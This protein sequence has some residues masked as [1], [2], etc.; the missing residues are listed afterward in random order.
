M[1]NWPRWPSEDTPFATGQLD[2]NQGINL[3]ESKARRLMEHRLMHHWYIFNSSLPHLG[4]VAPWR[5]FWVTYLPDLGLAHENVQFGMLATAAT[6]LLRSGKDDDV[7]AARQSY[8]L[9]ALH[10]QREQVAGLCAEN[11]EPVCFGALLITV[12][13][14]AMLKERDLSDPQQQPYQ[15]PL[16]WLQ[17]G[18]GAGT[19]LWQSVEAI[20]KESR[21]RAHPA[22]MAIATTYPYFGRDQSYFAPA[23]RAHFPGVL[24]PHLPPGD[25][26][27][28]RVD[29]KEDETREAY[30]KA[31]SYV[32]SIQRGIDDGEPLYVL[33]RRIQTF[34]LLAP[35]RFIGLLALRRPR[36]LVVLAH[37][38]AAVSQV[39]GV[40]WLGE[41][42]S[43]AADSTA[44]REIRA[45]RDA[46]PK[47]WMGTMVWPLDQVGLGGDQDVL[48]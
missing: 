4:S 36:A 20:V 17:L 25:D 39:K 8:F 37:F 44:V 3:P 40:W 48:A 47:E 11:A 6:H 19:A 22:L 41:A 29:E 23:M 12:C 45:I 28:A 42:D 38:W 21:E 9:S 24:S 46:L 5:S 13:S 16:E 7:Y 35:P 18:R 33:A 15:P 27:T 10:A 31:L 2:D 34:A 43:L 26:D 32:G 14:F 30:E 1:S